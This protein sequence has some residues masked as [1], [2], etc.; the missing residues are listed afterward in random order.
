MMKVLICSL[1]DGLWWIIGAGVIRFHHCDAVHGAASNRQGKLLLAC[2]HLIS[3]WLPHSSLPSVLLIFLPFHLPFSVSDLHKR[4]VMFVQR[5]AYNEVYIA[6]VLSFNTPF[7]TFP[8]WFHLK[9][10]F[11][12]DTAGLSNSNLVFEKL[13][14]WKALPICC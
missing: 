6:E 4:D 2:R 3:I 5:Q 11:F 13:K 9:A 7:W 10:C 12:K 8:L 1:Q 14:T